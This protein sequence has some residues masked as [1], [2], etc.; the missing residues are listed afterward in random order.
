LGNDFSKPNVADG[1]VAAAGLAP[2]AQIG[3]FEAVL[4]MLDGRQTGKEP[5]TPTELG[6]SSRPAAA[7]RHIADALAIEQGF[8]KDPKR[9][10]SVLGLDRPLF[11][12]LTMLAYFAIQVVDAFLSIPNC[13]W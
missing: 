4:R 2:F 12:A 9:C 7:R 3:I 8:A 1:S 5:C 11:K 10:K 6:N 13:G